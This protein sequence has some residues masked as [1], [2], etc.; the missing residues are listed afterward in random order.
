VNILLNGATP[1]E[2]VYCCPFIDGVYSVD[3]TTFE[4]PDGDPSAALAA[5]PP[6]WDW[7]IDNHREMMESH[8]A[9]RGFRAFYDAAREY[10]QPRRG[11]NWTGGEPPAYFPHQ[12]LRLELP[13][14]ARARARETLPGRPA[15]SVVLAGHSDSRAFYPSVSSWQL[16]LGA[17]SERFPDAV[18]CLIGKLGPGTAR[19]TSTITRAEVERVRARLPAIDCFDRPLLEQL[20]IVEASSLY[21]SP[22]SGFG[23]AAVSVGTPWLAISG[24]KWHEMFFNGVPFYS[25]IPNTDRYPCFDWEKPLPIV[26]ADEDGEGPRTASMNAARIR[27]DLPELL[28]GA[29]L[30]IERRLG[31][32]EALRQYFPRLLAA[33][34]GD[35]SRVFSFD[36]IDRAY[37]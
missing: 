22:H 15:I 20:A 16:I 3:Y 34:K 5:V 14:R 10:F 21:I 24:G 25:V 8:G 6:E 26:E 1:V 29:E 4:R 7:V 32:E 23:F 19:S 33:Y 17:L 31:Y 28:H 18:F 36:E 37:V 30:L 11:R 27:E 12:Q 2:L 9:A 13:E 35:R